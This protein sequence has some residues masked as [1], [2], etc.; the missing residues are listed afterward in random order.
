MYIPSVCGGARLGKIYLLCSPGPR[1][2]ERPRSFRK[3]RKNNTM[4]TLWLCHQWTHSG[5]S[6][7]LRS[8]GIISD[9][10]TIF[11]DVQRLFIAGCFFIH[12][13]HCLHPHF[14]SHS[15]SSAWNMRYVCGCVVIISSC[16]DAKNGWEVKL[17]LANATHTREDVECV[18][19][20]PD[21]CHSSERT[22][23]RREM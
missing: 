22:Q 16:D 2:R 15:L 14:T 13:R 11:A 9:N 18:R 4:S 12:S 5:D 3:I 17:R 19:K 23:E 10:S 20:Q 7:A 1:T 8:V 6:S 21:Q